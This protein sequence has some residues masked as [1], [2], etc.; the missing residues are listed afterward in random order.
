MADAAEPGSE[1]LPEHEGVAIVGMAGRFP[2]AADL[3]AFWSNLR[4]GVESIGRLSEEELEAAGV[5]PAV[6]GRSDYV[7][8]A[9]RFE[10]IGEFDAEFFGYTAREAQVM[11]PQH[12]L[13]LETSWQA[14]EDAG[15]D[16]A[17]HDGRI[18]VFG[19]A[20]TTAYLDNLMSNLEQGERIKG[21]NVGLAFELAFLTSRVSYKLGLR[22]PSFPVQT[23]CSSALVA[24]H[25]ACQSLLNFE[26]DMA[27]S[28]AVSYKVPENTGYVHQEGSFLSPDGHV[29][30]F[31]ADARGTVFGTGV[32]VVVL[33]R[34]EDAL[35]DR[36]TVHAVIRGSAVNNDGAVKASFT[37]P[38]ASGQAEVVTEA[39]AAA[40]ADPGSIGY[41]EAHGSG[42]LIGDSIEV[43]ALARALDTDRR[44][45]LGT[46]K[47]NVGH[48]D[49]A[50]GIAGLLKTTLA[51]EHGELPPTLNHRTPNPDIDFAATPFDVVTELTP[52][53]RGEHPRRAGVSAF[54]FG[55]TNAHLVLEEAPPEEPGEPAGAAPRGTALLTLS[56]R[57]PEALEDLTDRMAAHLRRHDPDLTDAG[58][59]LAVGRREFPHRRTVTGPDTGAV[60]A[61]L[62]TRDPAHTHT[63]HTA[64]GSTPLVFLFSGQGSQHPRMAHDLYRD[65]PH[66]RATVDEC[67]R[68][69]HPL[70]DADIRDLLLTTPDPAQLDR[71]RWTQPALFVLEYA[72]A[73]LWLHWGAAPTGMLGHSLG[74]WTAA[75][76]AGVFTLPDALRL[77]ALRGR[78][79]Q[80]QAPGAM[81]NTMA[82]RDEVE[83]AL[84]PGLSLAAHNGPRDCVV[85][86]P[87]EALDAFAQTAREHGWPTQPLTTSHAFHS[88][89]MAPMVEEFTAAVAAAERRPPV[90]PFVSNLTGD[91]ITPEQAQDPRYWGQHIL[92]TVEFAAGVLTAA[93][94]PHTTL[95]EVGPGQTLRSLARRVLNGHEH[96]ATTLNSLPHKRD[97][98]TA[99]QTLHQTL[100]QLWLHGTTPDWDAYHADRNPRRIPLPT[101]PFHRRKHWLEKAEPR[102]AEVGG[103]GPHPLLDRELLRSMGQ[104][105]FATE[106]A[107]ERHWVLSEHMMSG[108]AI[109]PG[110]TYL[111]MARAAATLH[112]G[113]PV[114][115][116]RDVTFLVPLLVQENA[117]RTVHTTVR[118]TGQDEAEFTVASLSPHGG[119]WTEHVR[120]TVGVRALDT[121]PVQDTAALHEL[122]SLD[123][124]DVGARQDGHRVMEFGERWTGSLR[125]V[126]VGVRA[127]LGRLDMPERYRP[128]CGDHALHPALLDLATGFSGLALRDGA[129]QQDGPNPAAD[130]FLPVGYD[131][132]L[133]HA[134]VPATGLSLV[135][136]R[137]EADNAEVRRADVLICDDD[138][139]TC[140]EI[141]G[142]T[143]KRVAD[144]RRT[145]ARLR[146]HTRHHAL[147]WRRATEALEPRDAPGSVLVVSERAGRGSALAAELRSRGV[148]VSEAELTGA[149]SAPGGGVHGVEPTPDGFDRLLDAL[150]ERPP[151]EVV[152]VAAPADGPCDDP[153]E[154]A[155]R[156]DHGVHSIF[157]LVRRLWERGGVPGRFSVVAPRVARVT[158]RE[159]ATAPV[160]ATLF[161]LA[162]VIG[163]ESEGTEVLCVDTDGDTGPG[164]VCDLLLA[165]RT[166]TVVAL[167]A[168]VRHVAELV[169]VD[170]RDTPAQDPLPE[171]GVHVITGGLGG[172]GLATA[173]HLSRT[174]PG[175]RLALVN[176]TGLPPRE[177]WDGVPADDTRLLDRIRA[178]RELEEHGARV[179]SYSGDVADP[180][181][182]AEIVRLVREEQGPISCVLHAA[183][184]AGDG[185]LFRKDERTFRRTLAPKV[186]G[187]AVLDLVTRD[188]PP[189]CMVLFGSTVSVFGAAG[190]S[191]YT[192]ANSYL[193]HF[194]E[195]RAARGLR[196]VT[197]DWSDWSETG[198]AFDHGVEEDRGFFRSLTTADAL[199]SFEEVMAHARGNVIVGEVN[200][201]RLGGP[202]AGG[203]DE[204][205]RRA[206]FVLS[207]PVRTAL[208]AARG[209]ARREGSP[210]APAAGATLFGR[211]DGAY[212][213]TERALGDIWARE[214]DLTDV[215]VHDSSFALGVDSLS[216]LRIAQSIQKS[217][218]V[219][220]S[221]VDLFRFTTVADLAAHLDGEDDQD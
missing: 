126:R 70:L 31:D 155:D 142:F 202:G 22:G 203:L 184:I 122:C 98:R 50:A 152:H 25:T 192:A 151:E 54:G 214:L 197:V 131:E 195:E 201:A 47:G 20:S 67:A 24:V 130:F 30:P 87:Q 121:P 96:P 156:L 33:K 180:E 178:V 40:D 102:A 216:A 133:V 97:P 106:F 39:L 160:H 208:A 49:A 88:E 63:A 99:V 10:G 82:D 108:E 62:E 57:T 141:R 137:P 77:V 218:D 12:R 191:D 34:L 136:T 167:R 74:E 85:S 15:Y 169:P 83:K 76:L 91:W 60:A 32:G 174:V 189:A 79:M 154:L 23:A 14:L 5:D 58:Y 21:E 36:D 48:L 86:G 147:R 38:T 220:V 207:P 80:D 28:G 75:T 164:P 157:H 120:G 71:T 171:N 37:A 161:G 118:E 11:D 186:L 92:A 127:A 43:Q 56:A 46:V 162:K 175:V 145:V 103:S 140:V 93:A 183:G 149:R 170:L 90:I 52:W 42:T 107:T 89:L 104:S 128:E 215:N 138:G 55:G 179:R 210:Q 196:T 213:D 19:G 165:R 148:H 65:E 124:V 44:I 16:A 212:T 181:R 193:G 105:V 7:R 172:L 18:G 51:L 177:E 114:T 219:R 173:R 41:V 221:M 4:E 211:Q 109:V 125:T 94:S 166:P 81:L 100:G 146:P 8:A 53:P 113:R 27:L 132:L 95:L 2:G 123:T 73:R 110:T 185:F 64:H 116:I 153:A 200:Y 111:E 26:C 198:M 17:R 61:A 66:F 72:L 217:L 190:Q 9:P 182:M 206:P 84:G 187:A 194:A 129:G 158:G 163:M 144:P 119:H 78:L 199:N 204:L 35:A 13:F 45:G 6:F 112:L 117:P 143:A 115:R 1:D 205:L 209:A 159:E 134:P 176:R 29:R 68:I 59:T 150:R 69:L 168:G 135:R 139:T 188:D 101:H 3:S